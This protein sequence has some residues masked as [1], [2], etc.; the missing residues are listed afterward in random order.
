MTENEILETI[1]MFLNDE[2]NV[3]EL[4]N[5]LEI[6]KCVVCGDYC[7]KEYSFSNQDGYYCDACKDAR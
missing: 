6:A 2:I 1:V 7:L 5:I 4:C 3:Q